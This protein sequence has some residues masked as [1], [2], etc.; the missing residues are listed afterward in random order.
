MQHDAQ[1]QYTA[2]TQAEKACNLYHSKPLHIHIKLRERQTL[3]DFR[4]IDDK[5]QAQQ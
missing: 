3:P 1:A 4:L 2:T 5:I